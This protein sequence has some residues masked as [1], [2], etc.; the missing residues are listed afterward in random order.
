[1]NEIVLQVLTAFILDMTIADPAFLPHPVRLIG[2]LITRAENI[3]RCFFKDKLE[4]FGGLILTLTIV[5][6][7]YF[8]VHFV[9]VFAGRVSNFLGFALGAYLIYAS[10][11]CRE[12]ADRA[13]DVFKDLKR[14]QLEQARKNLSGLVGRDT[15]NL[16]FEDVGRAVIETIA[17]N[18]ND[19]VVAPLFFAFLGGAPLAFTYRAVNTLD[20]MVGYKNEKYEKFGFVSAKLDDILNFI[21]ARI[22]GL[23]FVVVS[24]VLGKDLR[25]CVRTMLKDSKKHLSPNSGIPEAA[26]AGTLGVQLGGLSLY[27]GKPIP[28]SKLGESVRPLTTSCISEA[29]RI[30]YAISLL[31]LGSFTAVSLIF[32]RWGAK[33]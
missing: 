25:G 11:A 26:M 22:T 1:M 33:F 32:W 8:F 4:Y 9:L 18:I 23:F 30:H 17:E 31:A 3:L 6:F 29:I 10:I 5:A 14:G 2:F 27:D 28:K 7:S 12:L 15:D 21:P 20:S 24:L 16:S 19:A 13:K